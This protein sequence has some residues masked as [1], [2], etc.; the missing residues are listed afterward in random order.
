M[1]EVR[2]LFQEKHQENL[3][4]KKNNF[5]KYRNYKQRINQS[6]RNYDVHRIAL[7]A[8][9][10]SSMK[11]SLTIELQNF[12]LNFTQNNQIF[13]VDQRIEDDRNLIL[14]RLKQRENNERKKQ[15]N[16]NNNK[17]NDDFNKR[18]KNDENFDVEENNKNQFN[19]SQKEKSKDDKKFKIDNFNQKSIKFKKLYR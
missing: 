18:K 19:K 9:L 14:R 11:F 13:L 17:S 4:Q 2:E 10:H 7:F 1:N 16:V 12:V 5:E 8:N 6:I 15:R 3:H